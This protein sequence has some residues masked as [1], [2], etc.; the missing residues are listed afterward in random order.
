MKKKYYN[1]KLCGKINLNEIM[2]SSKHPFSIEEV[3]QNYSFVEK[4]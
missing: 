4:P 3:V 1:E 2:S